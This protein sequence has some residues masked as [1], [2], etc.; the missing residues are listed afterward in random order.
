MSNKRNTE[1][2]ITQS[3]LSFGDLIDYGT[4]VYSDAKTKIKFR[5]KKHDYS[6]EQTS[7][8]HL[9]SKHPCK[10]CLQ[11]SRRAA[12]SDSISTFKNKIQIIFGDQFDFEN[13][14]YVNQRTPISL[15]CL[16]HN[17]VITKEPEKIT[18]S[19]VKKVGNSS[20]L[21]A[22]YYS[23]NYFPICQVH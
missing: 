4:S 8:N 17:K 20:Y 5:C 9:Y 14:N 11:E 16:Q 7:N 21:K 12:L 23:F 3:K 13:A 22:Y 2:L 18:E 1:W 15:K 10:F 6:F 19:I